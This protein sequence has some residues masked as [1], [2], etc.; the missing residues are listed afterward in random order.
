VDL[1]WDSGSSVENAAAGSAATINK[2]PITFQHFIL[3][4]SLLCQHSDLWVLIP[5]HGELLIAAENRLLGSLA[6]RICNSPCT[7]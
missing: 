6:A 1:G 3:A 2:E 5:A 7:G 4:F